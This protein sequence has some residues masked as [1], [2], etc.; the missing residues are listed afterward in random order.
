METPIRRCSGLFED[1][2]WSVAKDGV[3]VCLWC[4]A[5]RRQRPPGGAVQRV[6]LVELGLISAAAVTASRHKSDGSDGSD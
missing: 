1:H 2:F 4:E 6:R 3:S 5:R